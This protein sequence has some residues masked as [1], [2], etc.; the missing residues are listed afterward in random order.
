MEIVVKM[1]EL[2][3]VGNKLKPKICLKR[4]L[5]YIQNISLNKLMYLRDFVATL[6]L[7]FF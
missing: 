3:T 1:S 5:L 2:K 6:L 7:N 4:V